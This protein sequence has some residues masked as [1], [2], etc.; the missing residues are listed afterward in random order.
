MNS[1]EEEFGV[2]RLRQ[3]FIDRPPSSAREANEAILE[4]V[5]HF[6]DG[7][8]QSDD[9]TCLVLRRVGV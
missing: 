8:P 7:H 2:E 1:E 9:V 4:A 3:I 6:A 5:K